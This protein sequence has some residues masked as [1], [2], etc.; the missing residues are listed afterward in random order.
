MTGGRRAL[1]LGTSEVEGANDSHPG[2][3][4]LD[5]RAAGAESK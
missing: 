5:S 4:N 3:R 2:R 1:L